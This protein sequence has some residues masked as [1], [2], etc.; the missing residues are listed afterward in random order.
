M[1]KS[2]LYR[3]RPLIEKDAIRLIQ[4]RP[5]PV[6]GQLHFEIVHT[7]LSHFKNTDGENQYTA[8][9]YV[10]GDPNQTIQIIVSGQQLN[11]TRNLHSAL[12]EMQD[13]HLIWADAVCI[14]QIDDIERGLQVQQMAEIFKTASSTIIHIGMPTFISEHLM[15]IE[16]S[17]CRFFDIAD[18]DTAYQLAAR[19]WF[20]R[21][22]IL[23]EFIL[24]KTVYL[25]WG[26]R[27]FPWEE[28][29]ESIFRMLD[30]SANDTS[31]YRRLMRMDKLRMK[32]IDKP[33]AAPKDRQ[34]T[35]ERLLTLLSERAGLGVQDP[36]DMLYAHIGL[37]GDMPNNKDLATTLT[38]DYTI[39]CQELYRRVSGYILEHSNNLDLLSYVESTRYYKRPGRISFLPSWCSDWTILPPQRETSI[40]EALRHDWG[41]R[42]SHQTK[43]SHISV[44]IEPYIFACPGYKIGIITDLTPKITTVTPWMRR[45][46]QP[47]MGQILEMIGHIL[48]CDTCTRNVIGSADWLHCSLDVRT[49]LKHH[50]LWTLLTCCFADSSLTFLGNRRFARLNNGS[51]ALVSADASQGDIVCNIPGSELPLL[52]HPYKS[53]SKTTEHVRATYQAK[54][55]EDE[56]TQGV[57]KQQIELRRHIPL[58]IEHYQ[59]VGEC[60]VDNHMLEDGQN[61]IDLNVYGNM[62]LFALH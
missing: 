61:N 41:Y 43:S 16:P 3:Y 30:S 25:Q 37:L 35:I 9:S 13:C 55:L 6:P 21:V 18:E 19:K 60:L 12:L 23:Q 1:E 44:Y 42:G 7:T 27:R 53:S 58:A 50:T 33:A 54:I 34:Q 36:R 28:V 11:I 29:V 47:H 56:N 49:N 5:S 32:Y 40:R 22:W 62:Q 59:F 31:V 38:V 17:V 20:R 39:S 57:S 48:V 4:S 15:T 26:K 46:D 2:S 52:S 45:G 10:C 8:I 51:F 24:S 14:N